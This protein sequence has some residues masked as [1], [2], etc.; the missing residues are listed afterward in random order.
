MAGGYD[1]I[2]LGPF[3]YNGGKFW[4]GKGHSDIVQIFVS[5]YQD[6]YISSIQYQY[7]ENG[8]LMLS[9]LHG[10]AYGNKF[11]VVSY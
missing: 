11:D 4:D 9:D 1:I 6:R 5:S 8:R 3:G 10:D 2:K 7:V